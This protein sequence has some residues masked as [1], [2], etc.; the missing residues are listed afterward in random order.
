MS[1]AVV[2]F[3]ILDA[4]FTAVVV[5][6]VRALSREVDA[7]RSK[8]S[9]LEEELPAA[10]AYVGDIV[11]SLE[12]RTDRIEEQLGE[13]AQ[14]SKVPPPPSPLA[15]EADV[16]VILDDAIDWAKQQQAPMWQWE[17]V[18]LEPS[19]TAHSG[20]HNESVVFKPAPWLETDYLRGGIASNEAGETGAF[21]GNYP[22]PVKVDQSV[23]DTKSIGAN[24][25]PNSYRY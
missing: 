18:V 1:I 24:T 14:R 23:I 25:Q 21:A 13:E 17:D 5:L 9:S 11:G 12:A 3:G 22:D 19:D 15:T 7:A 8:L 4:L 10:F 2:L 20:G 6:Y 16:F